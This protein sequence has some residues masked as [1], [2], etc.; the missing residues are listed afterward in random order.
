MAAVKVL[1]AYAILAFLGDEPSADQ[2][3]NLL[4]RAEEGKIELAMTIVNLGEVWYAIARADSPAT[5]DRLTQE[6]RSMAIEMVD[7]D[8]SLT[9][10][11][12]VLKA[13]GK[14]SFADCFAA[15][16]AKRRKGE[17][18]TGDPEFKRLAGDVKIVWL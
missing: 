17:V 13:R 4:L 3:R 7:A 10:E 16:L 5:A 9:R 12:S 8:W 14:A 15:A 2:V 11:A 18:V 6:V 1:D